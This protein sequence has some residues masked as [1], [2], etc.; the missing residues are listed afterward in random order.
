MSIEAVSWALSDA[1]DVPP[2]CLAVLIGL[3]NHAHADGRGAFPSQE[4]LAF[5][6]ASRSARSAMTSP[7]WPASA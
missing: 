7:N 3:A 1:P 4:R 2:S 5:Y 6:A